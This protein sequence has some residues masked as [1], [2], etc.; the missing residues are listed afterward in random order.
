MA[1]WSKMRL[2]KHNANMRL[3]QGW[4]FVKLSDG[5]VWSLADYRDYL[6]GN[7]ANPPHMRAVYK[8]KPS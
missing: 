6:E 8:E 2:L 5:S 4:K 1:K 3:E 7:P